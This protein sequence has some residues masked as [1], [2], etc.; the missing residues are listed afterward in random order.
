MDYISKSII[1]DWMSLLFLFVL[2]SSGCIY[3]IPRHP[4]F[5]YPGGILL[6]LRAFRCCSPIICT[7]VAHH[8]LLYLLRCQQ[9]ASIGLNFTVLVVTVLLVI[10]Y[11]RATN[12]LIIPCAWNEIYTH[13]H[14]LLVSVNLHWFIEQL[15][16]M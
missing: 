16:C 8:K 7:L 1:M 13:T 10:L 12:V 15:Y 14:C 11:F 5:T 3:T 2:T 9:F 6:Q 4:I